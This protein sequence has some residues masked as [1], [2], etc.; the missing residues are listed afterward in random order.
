MSDPWDRP[1]PAP[2]P[3]SRKDT[4][5]AIGCVVL[6]VLG[7]GGCVVYNGSKDPAPFVIETL[8]TGL[9]TKFGKNPVS[10][11]EWQERGGMFS[12]WRGIMWLRNG[13]EYTTITV[14]PFGSPQVGEVQTDRAKLQQA[15]GGR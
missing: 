14:P 13:Y 7:I 9:E 5:T 2:A 8:N 10:R 12:T 15:F 1:R 4:A 3:A 6:V 11:I